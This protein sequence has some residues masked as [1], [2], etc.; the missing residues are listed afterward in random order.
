VTRAP[1]SNPDLDQA[2]REWTEQPVP[3]IPAADA[4]EL[5]GRVVARMDAG[6]AERRAA[7][8]ASSI[9]RR[10]F[11]S[12]IAAC[13]VLATGL[14]LWRAHA[15]A[16]ASRVVV[17]GV[18][19]ATEIGADGM[20]HALIGSAPFGPDDELR[21]AMEGSAVA[22]LPTGARV[23]VGPSSRLRFD[24]RHADGHIRD[25]IDLVVGRIGVT[26]PKLAAG[27]EV[28]VHTDGATVIVHGTKFSV[29][30]T[31]AAPGQPVR[32]RVAVTEGRVAVQ[33]DAGEAI[34]MPGQS[35]SEPLPADE[36]AASGGRASGGANAPPGTPSTLAAENALLAEALRLARNHHPDDALSRLDALLTLYPDSPLVETARAERTRIL[37]AAKPG[38]DRRSHP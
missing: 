8:T 11:A 28:R 37:E 2:L 14:G 5:R 34:L 1:S 16:A 36:D 32:T 6:L 9:R 29:E 13:G 23:V 12:A 27:D 35:W 15:V 21:T 31:A 38:A 10:W 30:R 4:R 3:P 24:G 19:D 20:T 33:T 26:V 18:A 7:R 25:R 22:S 17:E